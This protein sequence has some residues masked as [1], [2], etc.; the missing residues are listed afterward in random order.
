MCRYSSS[1]RTPVRARRSVPSV[2]AKF[3]WATAWPMIF[4]KGGTPS[5]G[6][7]SRRRTFKRPG[8]QVLGGLAVA[9][10]ATAWL[11]FVLLDPGVDRSLAARAVGSVV[12]AA[13]AWVT[14]RATLHP[15]VVVDQDRL[16]IL[17]PLV[18]YEA[19]WSC[20]G[21]ADV[22]DGLR[23]SLA[24]HAPVTAWAFSGSLLAFLSGDAAADRAADAV[25]ARREGARPSRG[26][27]VRRLDLGLGQASAFVGLALVGAALA[28]L[29]DP[30]SPPLL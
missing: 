15:R 20:V 1:R 13:L 11:L 26:I 7:R 9:G 22:P 17:Q 8:T 19:P 23:V 5:A 2:R 18:R 27:V 25:N 3:A 16:L 24:G 12:L 14:W 30:T 21:S 4:G 28:W 29:L 10:F 6:R